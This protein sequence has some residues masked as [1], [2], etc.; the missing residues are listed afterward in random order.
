MLSGLRLQVQET[1]SD[2][3]GSVISHSAGYDEKSIITFL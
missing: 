3:G 2:Y 1:I